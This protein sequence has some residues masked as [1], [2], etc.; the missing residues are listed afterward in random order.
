[1]DETLNSDDPPCEQN[2][3]FHDYEEAKILEDAEEHHDEEFDENDVWFPSQESCSVASESDSM[4]IQGTV[5]KF[6]SC[7]FG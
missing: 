1:M 5:S 4:E 2:L 7:I 3:D 6:L